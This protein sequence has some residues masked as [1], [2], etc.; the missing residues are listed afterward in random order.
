M[1]SRAVYPSPWLLKWGENGSVVHGRCD[2]LPSPIGSVRTRMRVPSKTAM[3]PLPRLHRWPTGWPTGAPTASPVAGS[4]RAGTGTTRWDVDKLINYPLSSR[5]RLFLVILRPRRAAMRDRRLSHAQEPRP[6]RPRDEN[7]RAKLLPPRSQTSLKVSRSVANGMKST[8]M[9]RTM[10]ASLRA[11]GG[12]GV[13]NS[14]WTAL[15][16][17]YQKPLSPSMRR[18]C[19]LEFSPHL[20]PPP[21]G[22]RMRKS[23]RSSTTS[24]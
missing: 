14:S 9:R 16:K 20:H 7:K 21:Q 6:R 23:E 8:I 17:T 18:A 24:L 4:S 22:G 1:G 15:M 12:D 10:T 3:H 13:S 11:P 5:Y 2:Y 19:L